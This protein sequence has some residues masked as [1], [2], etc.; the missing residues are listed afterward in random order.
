[1]TVGDL[2][3]VVA[4]YPEKGRKP[5]ASERDGD[6]KQTLLL[7]NINYSKAQ[8]YGNKFSLSLQKINE[9]IFHVK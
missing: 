9:I 8:A 4:C 1:M 7:I 2:V 3:F 6:R 5:A